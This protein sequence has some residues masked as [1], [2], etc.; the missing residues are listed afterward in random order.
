MLV[1]NGENLKKA[2]LEAGL[3]I[4]ELSRLSKVQPRMISEMIHMPMRFVRLKTLSKIR[5]ALGNISWYDLIK[6]DIRRS[7]YKNGI[8]S[9]TAD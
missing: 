9:N 5:K 4:R 8:E 1:V 2:I 6:C 7:A 3:S